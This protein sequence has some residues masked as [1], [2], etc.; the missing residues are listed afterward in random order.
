MVSVQL[1]KFLKLI[2]IFLNLIL[3]VKGAQSSRRP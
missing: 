2:L 1:L 3:Q